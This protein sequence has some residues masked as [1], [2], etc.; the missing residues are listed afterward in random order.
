[1]A[2]RRV[3]RLRTTSP[4]SGVVRRAF[5]KNFELHGS[6]PVA[7]VGREFATDRPVLLAFAHA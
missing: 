1:M 3:T 7:F 5:A 6:T 4:R 2:R